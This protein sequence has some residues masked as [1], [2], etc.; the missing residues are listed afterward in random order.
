MIGYS[1]TLAM[2]NEVVYLEVEFCWSVG[3]DVEAVFG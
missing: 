3:P 1:D 2:I